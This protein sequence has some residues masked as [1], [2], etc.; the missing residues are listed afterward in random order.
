MSKRQGT[1]EAPGI[2]EAEVVVLSP[3]NAS[4]LRKNF[5]R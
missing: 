1:A 3:D 5:K 4:C 2:L